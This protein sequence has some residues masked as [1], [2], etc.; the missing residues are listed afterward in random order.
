MHLHIGGI[1][2]KRRVYNNLMHFLPALALYTVNSPYAGKEYYG[3]S[4]RIANSWAIGAIKEN[5]EI[6]FQDLIHSKRLGTL[7]IRV[8]DPVW[9]LE[10]VR[11]LLKAVEA[12]VK[13]EDEL[14]SARLTYNRIRPDVAKKGMT[15]EI[16]RIVDELSEI[17]EVPRELLERTASDEVK[18]RCEELGL[19][20]TYAAMDNA[21]R[22]GMMKPRQ[23]NSRAIAC[24]LGLIGFAGYFIPRLPYYAWKGIVE[25][26]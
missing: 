22:S 4:Y 26:N 11:Y 23:I 1:D 16:A 3:Q 6:R 7:E 5:W 9:D 24:A 2:E 12:V 19:I 14:P 18:E 13:L 21:Y 8:F 10:R 17:C 20:K 15:P 25:N